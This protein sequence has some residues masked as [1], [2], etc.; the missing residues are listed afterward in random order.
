VFND[1]NLWFIGASVGFRDHLAAVLPRRTV[2]YKML[3]VLFNDEKSAYEGAR[4]LTELNKEGSIDV[5]A[6]AVLQKV[7]KGWVDT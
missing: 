3:A 6:A 1:S 4:A 5:F 7:A 2:V